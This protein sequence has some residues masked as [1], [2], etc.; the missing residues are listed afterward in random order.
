MRKTVSDQT[1]NTQLSEML[2]RISKLEAQMNGSPIPN[3]RIVSLTWNKS[4]GG[5]AILGGADDVSGVLYVKD[6][7]GNIRIILDKDGW[8]YYDSEGNLIIRMGLEEV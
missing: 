2:R 6:E 4:Q 7:N 5:E 8:W 1:Y 3:A